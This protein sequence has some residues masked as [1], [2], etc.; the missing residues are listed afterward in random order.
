[1]SQTEPTAAVPPIDVTIAA[2]I[3]AATVA[4]V[5]AGIEVAV[6]GALRDAQHLHHWNLP[7][8]AL[9]VSLR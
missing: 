5:G 3:V 7:Y 6:L 1:M 8:R 9:L 4:A 2:T